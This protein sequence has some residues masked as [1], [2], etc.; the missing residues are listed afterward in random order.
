M[1]PL[2]LRACAGCDGDPVSGY[3]IPS[4]VRQMEEAVLTR[5]GG[6]ARDAETSRC[7]LLGPIQALG[8]TETTRLPFDIKQKPSFHPFLS[9]SISYKIISSNLSHP[10]S[11]Q[12]SSNRT[13]VTCS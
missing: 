3:L 11:H 8:S 5:G 10:Q 9:I 1:Q 12:R 4:M 2:S 6:G 7:S 13:Q